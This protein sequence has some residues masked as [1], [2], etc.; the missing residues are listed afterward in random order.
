M[1]YFMHLVEMCAEMIIKLMWR[2]EKLQCV[3]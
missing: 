3:I 1:F 2:T